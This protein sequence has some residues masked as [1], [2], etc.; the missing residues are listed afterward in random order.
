MAQLSLQE[1]KQQLDKVYGFE[2]K[3]ESAAGILYNMSII[4]F[5][6]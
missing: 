1:V 4:S 3:G 2:K 6:L 5:T